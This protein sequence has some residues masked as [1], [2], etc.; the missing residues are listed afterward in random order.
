MM[1]AHL[2]A[3]FVVIEVGESIKDFKMVRIDFP[4]VNPLR[5]AVG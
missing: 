3:R 4:L 2:E 1:L 5:K